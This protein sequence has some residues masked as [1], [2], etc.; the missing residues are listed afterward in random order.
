MNSRFSLV[1]VIVF[2]PLLSFVFA[3]SATAQARLD[4]IVAVVDKEIIT[5]SELMERVM[6]TAMQNRLDPADTSLRSEILNGL[7]AEKLVLAQALIDSVVVTDEDVTRQLDTQIDNFIR[8]AGS[9]E[10]LEQIYG[11]PLA[12][13]KR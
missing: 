12:R 8:R 9:Q 6:L 2:L 13:I 3:A 10:K 7:I 1:V 4:R 5:E 11:M